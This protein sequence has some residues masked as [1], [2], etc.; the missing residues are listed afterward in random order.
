MGKKEEGRKEQQGSKRCKLAKKRERDEE[1]KKK[2]S[3]A[4]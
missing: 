2:G 4:I 3:D 1:S